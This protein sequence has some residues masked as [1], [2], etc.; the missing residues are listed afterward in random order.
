M[1]CGCNYLASLSPSERSKVLR[2]HRA[3][4]AAARLQDPPAKKKPKKD[5]EGIPS[6]GALYMLRPL[7]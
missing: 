1:T 5:E 6:V 4:I 7:G 2:K 3:K